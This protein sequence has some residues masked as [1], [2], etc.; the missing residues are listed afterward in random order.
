MYLC[1]YMSVH[2]CLLFVCPYHIQ[3]SFLF[4][5]ICTTAMSHDQSYFWYMTAAAYV[6]WVSISSYCQLLGL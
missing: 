1:L 6:G 2:V 3:Q 4:L 5:D